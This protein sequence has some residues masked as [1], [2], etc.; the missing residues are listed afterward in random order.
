MSV[1]NCTAQ[2]QQKVLEIAHSHIV[3]GMDMVWVI[4][5]VFD[6]LWSC[7]AQRSSHVILK[8]DTS[9]LYIPVYCDNHNPIIRTPPIQSTE[10]ERYYDTN[11]NV[12]GLRR[13]RE[14]N[15]EFNPSANGAVSWTWTW[16]TDKILTPRSSCPI[17]PVVP[18]KSDCCFGRFSS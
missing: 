5:G 4:H 6:V 14:S 10:Q 3:M 13:G 8:S 1:S 18:R 15:P 12:V 17:V 9:E 2:K 11:V 7:T 16:T